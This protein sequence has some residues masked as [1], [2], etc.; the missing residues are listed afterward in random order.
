[1]SLLCL[2]NNCGIGATFADMAARFQQLYRRRLYTHHFEQYIELSDMEAAYEAVTWLADSYR[3][4]DDVSQP[5]D[6]S[7][8]R[9]QEA[10]AAAAPS[11][12]GQNSLLQRD[13]VGAAR[14][15]A[16]RRQPAGGAG[17]GRAA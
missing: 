12:F 10:A 14:R 11:D 8:L 1:M 9:P 17:R 3:Q 5:P 7:R 15:P 16:Q 6:L 4:L 2:A 13:D